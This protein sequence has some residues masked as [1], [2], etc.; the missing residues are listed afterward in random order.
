MPAAFPASLDTFLEPSA[1][2]TTP[3]G[4]AGAG[5]NTR[6]HNAHHR[7]LG[8][9][10]EAIEAKVGVDGSAVATTIDFKLSTVVAGL[11]AHL[12][13]TV[14][15][16]DASAISFVPTGSISST[17]VQ[18]A[19]A[20]VAS[21]ALTS[22]LTTRGDLLTRNASVHVRLPL[23]ATAGAVFQS[24]GTDP[25]WQTDPSL[26]TG[27]LTG[28]NTLVGGNLRH[29]T[30]ARVN[31]TYTQTAT[32]ASY[33]VG[34]ALLID[35]NPTLAYVGS[36]NVGP[37]Y[38]TGFFGPRA[39]VQVEGKA[40]YN[41]STSIFGQAPI[42]FADQLLVKNNPGSS[43]NFTPAFVFGEGR[44]WVADNGTVNAS[45]LSWLPASYPDSGGFGFFDNPVFFT[46]N[47]GTLNLNAG[48]NYAYASFV[49]VP[50]MVGNVTLSH[51]VGYDVYDLEQYDAATLSAAFGGKLSGS[52]DNVSP[53]VTRQTGLR[54]PRLVYAATNVG[55][56]C[57]TGSVLFGDTATFTAVPVPAVTTNG[58][59][60]LNFAS[61]QAPGAWDYAPTLKFQQDALNLGIGLAATNPFGVRP[62]IQNLSSAT[63]V[64][65]RTAVMY[66]AWPTI[67]AD[68]KTDVTLDNYV[69]FQD[70][71]TFTRIN[72]GVLTASN[73]FGFRSA[74]TVATGVTVGTVT[75][76]A[77]VDAAGAGT[78]TSQ[79]GVDVPRLAKAA[80]TNIGIRNNSQTLL[81]DD[82]PTFTAN[83]PSALVS[84]GTYTMNVTGGGGD[85]GSFLNL[86][87]TVSWSAD[88]NVILGYKGLNVAPTHSAPGTRALGIHVGVAAAP[89]YTTAAAGSTQTLDLGFSHGPVYSRTASGTWS[90]AVTG[91]ASD[92]TAN[93]GNTI[94]TRTGYKFNDGG[95]AG[96]FTTQIGLDVAALSKAT[97]NIGIRNAA[98]TVFTPS[99]QQTL[100][101]G[102]ALLANATVVHVTTTGAVTSTAAPTIAN[103]QDG[104]ILIIT[105]DGA[106]TS[107]T[108]QDQGTLANSNLRLVAAT[109]ALGN[110]DSVMLMYSATVGDWI[111]ITPVLN[112][113]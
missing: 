35:W 105:Y 2:A 71:P 81:W 89:A 59:Y 80:T 113:L 42:A 66:Q 44:S 76:L 110:R 19:I 112:V 10:V 111:Q 102:T 13:D 31:N 48:G 18:A 60:T 53:T 26:P 5:G 51:R 72:S 87:H 57:D 58:V 70:V 17:D 64:D 34:T 55:V 22:P 6:T 4:Q 82:S 77:V 39:V 94:T 62:T 97:T 91:F 104:Q 93:A 56:R 92:A 12:A 52:V 1:P 107:W 78:V 38:S 28:G 11:A 23:S 47:T 7:D 100:A 9:A 16:H 3:L 73:S 84:N 109:V 36:V 27:V 86:A 69:G 45:K 46:A 101:A 50:Y 83:P 67:Q 21:E 99:G 65:L 79:Y 8:D 24:D 54:V 14:D 90:A 41:N 74:P 37:Q 68:T 88:P 40:Q 103:G 108:M 96:S 106:G 63:G 43:V 61:A 33:E 30:S 95:G 25:G 29:A 15:A 98:S 20:E 49:S 85:F 75:G 32:P